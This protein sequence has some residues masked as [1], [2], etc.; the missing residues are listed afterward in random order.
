MYVDDRKIEEINAPA[1]ENVNIGSC[2]EKLKKITVCGSHGPQIEVRSAHNDGVEICAPS[3]CNAEVSIY[4]G[5]PYR[6]TAVDGLPFYEVVNSEEKWTFSSRFTSEIESVCYAKKRNRHCKVY[7]IK[8]GG[9]ERVQYRDGYQIPIAKHFLGKLVVAGTSVSDFYNSKFRIMCNE[10]PALMAHYIA[11]R[12]YNPN[13]N[14]VL[15]D[16][17]TSV[18][19]QLHPYPCGKE[20]WE[21]EFEAQINSIYK[22]CP[23]SGDDFYEERPYF[24]WPTI[25]YSHRRRA[26]VWEQG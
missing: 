23:Y 25:D 19:K 15:Y 26:E 8:E 11:T 16:L 2:C 4:N 5:I 17:I 12:D 14:V 1:N 21:S 7:Y 13:T 3:S 18:K 22:S 10:A 24:W 20:M 6:L 9:R